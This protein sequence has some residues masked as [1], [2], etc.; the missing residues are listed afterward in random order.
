MTPGVRYDFASD[1]TAGLYPEALDALVTANAGYVASYGEDEWTTRAADGIRDLFDA[2][3][4]VYFVFNGTAANSLALATLCQSYHSVICH[5]AAH[6]ETDECGAPEFFS[7]GTKV[8]VA[9]GAGGR[10]D[11]GAVE[12]LITRRSDLHY[13]KPR[14][15]SIT[16]STEVGTRYSPGQTAELC[17][18]AHRH[19]LRVHLD[20]ARFLQAVAASGSTPHELSVGAGIDVLTLGGVKP[21]FALGEAVVF[22]D[23]GLSE[24]FSFRCKQ[25]GQLSSKMRFLAAP[26]AAALESGSWRG[27]AEHAHAMARR[28]S[29]GLGGIEGVTIAHPVE[30]NGVFARLPAPVAERL[31]AAGWAFYDF[32]GDTARFMCSWSTTEGAVDELVTVAAG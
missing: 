28:L 31:R 20:G 26:W 1:N 4:D 14:A 32:I 12:H 6:V 21:G 23:R 2:D 9:P 29:A 10:L 25:A 7:H 5:E 3:C 27:H 13:P 19:G 11:P 24:E 15:L 17:D 30:A 16:Q 18:L 22:F 8:L